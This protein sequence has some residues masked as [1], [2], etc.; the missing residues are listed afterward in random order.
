[1][2]ISESKL[3][4]KPGATKAMPTKKSEINLTNSIP[5]N[6]EP[7]EELSEETETPVS[8]MPE[9]QD[10]K[11]KLENFCMQKGQVAPIYKRIQNKTNSMWSCKV[12]TYKNEYAAGGEFR[13]RRQA[14]QVSCQVAYEKLELWEKVMESKRAGKSLLENKD[15]SKSKKKG[16]P[17]GQP[18]RGG[19][20][21]GGP[22][23]LRPTLT[24]KP[25]TSFEPEAFAS[26]GSSTPP[27]H[28]Q[29]TNPT[30]RT[31]H[32]RDPSK[33]NQ[34][35]PSN[36]Q[37]RSPK[38]QQQDYRPVNSPQTQAEPKHPKEMMRSPN[39]FHN[40]HNNSNPHNNSFA[41]NHSPVQHHQQPY[42]EPKYPPER[43]SHNSNNAFNNHNNFNNYPNETRSPNNHS[44]NA[45][46]NNYNA[47]QQYQK[48]RS[49]LP[50]QSQMPPYKNQQHVNSSQNNIVYENF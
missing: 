18:R 17:R 24:Y 16:P 35:G 1:M 50:H 5:P 8:M 29:T 37:H 41:G 2:G 33:P 40:T 3:A 11:K 19:K 31:P 23:P 4:N 47:G 27:V 28:P 36:P 9:G 26:D 10:W 46:N 30:A 44:N 20:A 32:V 14:V 38:K 21:E 15:N 22:R 45:F 12:I 42:A 43:S 49:E 48:T 39:N 25:R 7:G 34:R 6:N 13:F